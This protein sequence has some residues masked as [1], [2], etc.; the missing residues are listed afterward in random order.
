MFA[1]DKAFRITTVCAKAKYENSSHYYTTLL[2]SQLLHSKSTLRH[3]AINIIYHYKHLKGPS[4]PPHPPP[5]V[6]AA[7]L[8][9]R[10]ALCC[11][12]TTVCHYEIQRNT[13]QGRFCIYWNNI[14]NAET[15]DR[16]KRQMW[17]QR[18]SLYTPNFAGH[19]QLS[20]VYL[21]HITAPIYHRQWTT[22]NK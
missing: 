21:I 10:N 5:I 22:D 17:W 2:P 9:C 12:L 14:T 4:H 11:S 16:L 13:E 15:R 3:G 19:S 18:H 1:Q 6:N 20:E 8:F 7:V